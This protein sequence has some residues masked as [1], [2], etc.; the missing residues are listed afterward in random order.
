MRTAIRIAL[1]LALL[2]PASIAPAAE[3][4]T[5]AVNVVNGVL[6]VGGFVEVT[7]FAVEPG[8][9]PVSKVQLTLDRS[10]SGE[11]SLAGLRPDVLA[12]FNRPDFLW[13]GWSG[14]ISL[15][16]V[17]PGRHTV[18]MTAYSHSGEPIPCGAREIQVLAAASPPERPALVIALEML[19]RLALF[20]TGISILGLGPAVATGRGPVSLRAPFLGLAI[21][22]IGAEAGAGL[23]L[24]PL[25]SAL[26]PAAL[27][28]LLLALP[29]TRRRW[30]PRRPAAGTLATLLCAAIFAV[31]GA[32]ALSSHGEGVVLGDI[33][34]AV[35][36]CAVADSMSRY[37]PT[38]PA[39]APGYVGGM[40]RE[41]RRAGLRPGGSY[42]L[43]AVA[44]A[45]GV[46]AHAVHSVAT[47]GAGVLVVLGAG[48]LGY[49][50]LRRFPR[51][52]W[53]P[54]ALAAVNSILYATLANQ[55]LGSLL[56]AALFLGFLFHLLELAQSR[57]ALAVVPVAILAAAAWTDYPE[58][59][60]TWAVA[61]FLILFLGSTA[62]RRR[63]ILRLAAAAVLSAALNPI[64]LASGLR[65]LSKISGQ[66]ALATP[67][68]REIVGDTHYFPSLNV[69]AGTIAYREDAPAPLGRL[70]SILVPVASL[71]ILAV[72]LLGWWG[73]E[74]RERWLVAL[75]V[76]PVA[77]A[78]AVNLRL[79]FPYGFAKYL[80]LAVPL[81]AVAFS[82]LALRAASG[83]RMGA[84]GLAVAS[85]LVVGALS[86]PATRHVVTRILRA[87]PAYDPGYRALPALAATVDR[88]AVLFVDE[89]VRARLEWMKYFLG[90]NRVD[91]YSSEALKQPNFNAAPDATGGK[92]RR[93]LVVDRRKTSG[94]LPATT[95]AASRDFA[96]VSDGSGAVQP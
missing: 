43:S 25:V 14:R 62:R 45:S 12:H 38:P 24:R 93:F 55:H 2:G 96:L 66:S 57:S 72:S 79:H 81:W 70:R 21:L 18:E 67:Y 9:A 56:F 94:G 8:G 47:L 83:P 82:L 88:T 61:G 78:L 58:G 40:T 63:T 1:F 92:P 37:G 75:L 44:Q 69:V 10:R 35:R 91:T 39:D 36:E 41:A 89:P 53:L 95:V 90:D 86:L 4:R 87:V 29:R 46:R 68:A 7:G 22:A 60:A 84:R 27:S 77:L 13:S 65:S 49:R 23:G 26:L 50:A 42:L 11:V 6:A 52:R 34:D 19:G 51:F 71:L 17:A 33:D 76:L 31:V 3:E 59:I 48:L 5:C 64:G 80:P 28:L 32:A 15:E 74:R 30:K 16:K 54:S 85:L 73:L 20:L